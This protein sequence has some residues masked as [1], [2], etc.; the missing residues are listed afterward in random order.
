MAKAF[1]RRDILQSLY[2][3]LS[4]ISK[5]YMPN[6]PTATP[7]EVT[8]FIVVDLPG[9]MRDLNAYQDATLRVDLFKKDFAGNIEDVNGLDALYKSVIALFPI[10]TDKFTAISPRLAAGGSDDKGYHFLMIYANILTK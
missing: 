2:T 3:T 1:P 5:V 4:G 9:T 6:R 8:S 7:T 10:V